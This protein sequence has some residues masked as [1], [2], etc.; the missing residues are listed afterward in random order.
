MRSMYL[1]YAEYSEDS[2]TTQVEKLNSYVL[3]YA[4][5]SVYNEAVGY[6][7]YGK[8]QSS[9]VVPLD[10]P[11]VSREFKSMEFKRFV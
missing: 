3:D 6:M 5:N 11:E 8:D 2:V 1:Q 4:V 9:L 7:N 10:R